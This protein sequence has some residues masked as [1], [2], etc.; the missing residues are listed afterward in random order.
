LIY[1]VLKLKKYIKLKSFLFPKIEG[2]YRDIFR[3]IKDLNKNISVERAF[4]FM[5]MGVLASGYAYT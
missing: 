5:P 4:P 2:N 3:D 1:Y